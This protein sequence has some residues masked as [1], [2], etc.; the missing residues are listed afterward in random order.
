MT[1]AADKLSMQKED[2]HT[3]NLSAAI[4]RWRPAPPSAF[5]HDGHRCCTTAR[6]W[7]LATDQSQLSGEHK[8]TGPRWLLQKYKW[9]PSQWP[10]TWCRA[11]EEKYL[12][13][14]AL[15]AISKTVF[16]AR[17]VNAYAVQLIQEYNELT[18]YQWSKKWT[19][20][21]ASTYWIQGPL[22]YHEACAVAIAPNEIKIWD[23]SAACWINAKQNAGYGS[24]LAMRIRNDNPKAAKSINWG[25]HV[26]PT[27]EWHILRTRKPL[28][29]SIHL[30]KQ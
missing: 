19:D 28:V 22:I 29:A 7:L 24:V 27:N 30:I 13:C 6:E 12:D 21:R 5:M 23:S 14:G 9:G 26:V 20:H 2:L 1:S 3:L 8:L 4:D 15:A 18:T 10:M 16:A 25:E 17:S 11:V